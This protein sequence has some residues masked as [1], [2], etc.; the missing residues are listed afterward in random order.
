M[1]VPDGHDWCLQARLLQYLQDSIE[2]KGL[3][4]QD[5]LKKAFMD[6]NSDL[7]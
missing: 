4:P 3:Q 2:A 6:I 1:L 5:A 7:R